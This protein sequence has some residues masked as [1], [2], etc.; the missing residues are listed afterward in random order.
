[1]NYIENSPDNFKQWLE[2]QSE[3]SIIP[4]LRT[5]GF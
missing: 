3:N 5:S 2:S 4:M 1:M